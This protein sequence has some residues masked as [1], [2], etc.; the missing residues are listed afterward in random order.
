MKKKNVSM[1]ISA[2][3]ARLNGDPPNMGAPTVARH[4][5]ETNTNAIVITRMMGKNVPGGS[6]PMCVSMTAASSSFPETTDGRAATSASP[7][8]PKPRARRRIVRAA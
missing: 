2:A 8:Q 1:K 3:I 4:A 5:G 7:R 6:F